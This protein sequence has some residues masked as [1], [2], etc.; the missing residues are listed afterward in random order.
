[1]NII[2]IL[3]LGI[4][5]AVIFMIVSAKKGVK[6]SVAAILCILGISMELFGASIYPATMF[7]NIAIGVLCVGAICIISG[8][9]IWVKR[10]KTSS[11]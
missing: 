10:D 5:L 1:M 2:W 9:V 11:K 4:L 8:V 3:I 6:K 7:R